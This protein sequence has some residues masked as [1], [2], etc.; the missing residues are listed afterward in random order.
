M[1]WLIEN[2]GSEGTTSFYQKGVM[3]PIFAMIV[4]HKEQNQTGER[5][6]AEKQPDPMGE[7][8]PN[9]APKLGGAPPHFPAAIHRRRNE[10]PPHTPIFT[11]RSE[12]CTM[13]LL[14]APSC[15]KN[16]WSLTPRH[17]TRTCRARRNQKR[18]KEKNE[19]S[20]LLAKEARERFI[21]IAFVCEWQ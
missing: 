19:P 15:L 9:R 2:R 3:D 7:P 13:T 20:W 10:K 8:P 12:E 6:R 16:Q 5:E 21:V 17:V 4:L 14:L 18:N 11:I 1:I